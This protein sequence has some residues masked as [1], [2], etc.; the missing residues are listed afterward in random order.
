[1]A[2]KEVMHHL[3]VTIP[4]ESQQ[5]LVHRVGIKVV[6]TAAIQQIATRQIDAE[7]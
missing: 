4:S 5:I 3:H 6:G 1:M 2:Y 7:V